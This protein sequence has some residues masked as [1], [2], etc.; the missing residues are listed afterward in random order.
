MKKYSLKFFSR[1]PGSFM[2]S[3]YPLSACLRKLLLSYIAHMRLLI[4]II[5]KN[6]VSRDLSS[7]QSNKE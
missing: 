5:I 1:H 6:E 4:I 2:I 3:V 7:H